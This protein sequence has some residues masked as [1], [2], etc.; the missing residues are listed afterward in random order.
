MYRIRAAAI[1][2]LGVGLAVSGLGAPSADAAQ[3]SSREGHQSA[4][5]ESGPPVRHQLRTPRRSAGKAAAIAPLA[6]GQA[7][8][9]VE[10]YGVGVHLGFLN[11]PYVNIVGVS[12]ALKELGVRH[13]RDDL[14]LAVSQQYLSINAVAQQAG[15]KFDLIM[16]RPDRLFRPADYVNAV[17][18]LVTPGAVESLE[19]VNEW[20]L[21]GPQ[22]DTNPWV[23][24]MKAWQQELY[25]AAKA[26]PAT[27][28]LPILSPSL[29]FRANYA[30]A[31]DMSAYADIANAHMYPGG[32]RPSNEIPQIT[33]AL[34]TSIPTKPLVVTESGY[35]NATSYTGG[36]KGVPE[37]VGGVYAPRILLEH[38]KRG[39]Q[40][41]YDYEL[42]DE[43]IDPG[44]TDAESN[45][46]L[47]HSDFSPKPAFTATKNLLNL[48]KD[49]GP[50]FTP[51]PLGITADGMPSDARYLFVQKRNGQYV[52]LL[53]RDVDIYNPVT[54]QNIAVTPAN[55][56][57]RLDVPYAMSVYRPSQ[58]AAPVSSTVAAS[59]PVSLDGQVTA[60]TIDKAPPPAPTQVKAAPGNKTATVTWTLPTTSA[61]VTGFEVNRSPGS[62]TRTVAPTLRT[63]KDTGLTNKT[64]YTYKVRTLTASGASAWVA[65]PVVT[66]AATP[67][68]PRITSLRSGPGTAT[69]TWRPAKGR[70]Q[71]VTGYRLIV[72]GKKLIV[73]RGIHRATIKGLPTGKRVKIVLQA[74]NAIGWSRKSFVYYSY[75]RPLG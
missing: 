45:F 60:I 14:I 41:V 55:V 75:A 25:T 52:L 23:A 65:A 49:P 16:G 64:K 74:R 7:D 22:G 27:A 33:A 67:T 34:R 48:V 73:P 39:H 31:G 32:Y 30:K 11:T 62:V 3:P 38:V 51:T 71:K 19:G 12:N 68:S 47:L 66:P 1:A 5:Q 15:V 35:H 29:A 72:G 24:E 9:L 26:Q 59:V 21:F 13:V 17:A 18:T 4:K 58:G 69:V 63:F 20:D 50:A 46:G 28:N 42:L 56:T 54:Q 53:W 37:S 57:V 70:G 10:S 61:T 43:F 40:R 2:C 6:A 8:A 36:H 44:K